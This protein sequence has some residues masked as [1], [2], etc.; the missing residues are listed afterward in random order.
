MVKNIPTFSSGYWICRHYLLRLLEQST[1]KMVYSL[2]LIMRHAFEFQVIR[3]PPTELLF[4]SPPTLRFKRPLI[5]NRAPILHWTPTELSSSSLISPSSTFFYQQATTNSIHT[6]LSKKTLSTPQLGRPLPAPM[7][8]DAPRTRP[9]R[10]A[11]AAPL[12]SRGTVEVAAAGICGEGTRERAERR[13]ERYNTDGD[14][15]AEEQRGTLTRE[16][17]SGRTS[18]AEQ[19]SGYCGPRA[20]LGR[21]NATAHA[22]SG[23]LVPWTRCCG[24]R[25]ASGCAHS[26]AARGKRGKCPTQR[27]RSGSCF[28][29][30]M[31]ALVGSS[32]MWE[33]E[34]PGWESLIVRGWD[35]SSAGGWFCALNSQRRVRDQMRG[36][37]ELPLLL[38]C[39]GHCQ[40]LR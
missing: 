15:G 19:S 23:G 39:L 20:V 12:T 5:L 21:R 25:T 14:A 18:A 9:L 3:A 28:N 13:S 10:A 22:A 11:V 2:Y 33:L 7:D 24:I 26:P 17:E 4:W 6:K 37:L 27:G 32:Y 35:K 31:R 38:C 16:R 30:R 40:P 1:S 29:R 36:P 8:V 34:R